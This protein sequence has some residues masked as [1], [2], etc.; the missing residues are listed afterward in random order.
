MEEKN[1]NTHDDIEVV[2][3]RDEVHDDIEIADEEELSLDKM[4]KLREKL[5]VCEHDKQE[6]LEALQRSRA[7]FLNYKRRTEDEVKK[8]DSSGTARSVET[9]LPLL[10]SFALAT[11][12]TAWDTADAG[13]KAG[14]VM[15]QSQLAGILKELGAESIIP[16]GDLFNPHEHEAIAEVEADDDKEHCIIDTVQPGYKIG[17]TTI[18]A[19]RVVVGKKRG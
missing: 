4:K 13:F 12:G 15:I 2:T 7:D 9:L 11:K 8:R 19:A 3:G 18:R 5:R 16:T 17:S 14:F 1:E 6:Y 10:D